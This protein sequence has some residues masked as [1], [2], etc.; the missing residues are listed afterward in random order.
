M[1][2]FKLLLLCEE[3]RNHLSSYWM[4]ELFKDAYSGINVKW[5]ADKKQEPDFEI[6]KN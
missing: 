2:P 6:V 4:S 3:D 5:N 1:N